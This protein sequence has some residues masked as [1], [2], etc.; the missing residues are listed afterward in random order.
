[1]SNIVINVLNKLAFKFTLLFVIKTIS[2][3]KK[4]SQ[5]KKTPKM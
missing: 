2:K 3:L 4:V 1:M 5:F